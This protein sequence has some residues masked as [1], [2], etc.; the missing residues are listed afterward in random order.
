MGISTHY[1]LLAGAGVGGQLQPSKCKPLPMNSWDER[2]GG[3]Q[4]GERGACVCIVPLQGSR[5]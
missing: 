2:G 1:Q 5:C 4:G 3:R